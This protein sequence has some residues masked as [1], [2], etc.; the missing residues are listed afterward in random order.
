MRF[1]LYAIPTHA[2]SEFSITL[3][4]FTS[5]CKKRSTH[6][7]RADTQGRRGTRGERACTIFTLKDSSDCHQ[8][9]EMAAGWCVSWLENDSPPLHPRTQKCTLSLAGG[10]NSGITW[11]AKLIRWPPFN[12]LRHS[13]TTQRCTKFDE[14]TFI[15]KEK[16]SW[17]SPLPQAYT[18]D[19]YK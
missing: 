6:R 16:N 18:M 7:E 8:R 10:N 2:A 15:R 4:S 3:T 9:S 1:S 17:T 14:N 5:G 13:G 12:A 19:L 11:R